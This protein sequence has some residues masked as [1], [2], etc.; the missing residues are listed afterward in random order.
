M[1]RGLSFRDAGDCVQ[2]SHDY[3][4]RSDG[5]QV[6]SSTTKLVVK[7]TSGRLLIDIP[8]LYSTVD[9][10]RTETAVKD[11]T[12]HVTL[13]KFTPDEKWPTVQHQE[14]EEV[15]FLMSTQNPQS[16]VGVSS[17]ST[18]SGLRTLLSNSSCST[19]QIKFGNA[20]PEMT[21]TISSEHGSRK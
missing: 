10:A 19:R 4:G 13:H 3:T 8:Q 6:Q 5:V 9:A 11:G 16:L 7:D 18:L 2:V 14:V 15:S 1:G 17:M 21:I 20:L 12:L